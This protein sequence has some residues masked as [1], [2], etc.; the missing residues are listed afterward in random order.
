[1]AE[2]EGREGELP[3]EQ[4]PLEE[5][6]A[7]IP[8]DDPG[9]DEETGPSPAPGRAYGGGVGRGGTPGGGAGAS[10]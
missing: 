3:S 9:P 10:N 8:P 7:G 6:N 1:M 5:E 2:D 4:N